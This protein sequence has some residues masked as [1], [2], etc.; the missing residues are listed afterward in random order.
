MLHLS[1]ENRQSI[2]DGLKRKW[3]DAE[4][5]ARMSQR[6]KEMWQSPE[7]RLKL[8]LIHKKLW[9][10]PEY[11]EK[12]L[13]SINQPEVKQRIAQ[14]SAVISKRNWQNPE[15]IIKMSE[16]HK[17]LW[18][19]PEFAKMMSE[20][21]SEAALKRWQD[22]EYR[23]HQIE[24]QI[25]SW[26]DPIIAGKRFAGL[27]KKPTKPEQRLLDIFSKHLPQFQYN[28]DFRL[29]V[30]IGGLI[31]DF[32]NINGRKEVIE[33]FGDYH[34]SPEVIG[35]DWRRGELGKIMIYNSLGWKCFVIWQSELDQLSD[36]EVIEKI[37]SFFARGD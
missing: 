19:D 11:R 21:D 37:E 2:N 1:N 17:Q 32:V 36:T 4:Y 3:Q 29:E 22:P 26:Q 31:P 20:A 34:H 35:N 10:D 25:K 13:V 7:Y 15:F 27:N 6:R 30:M 5:K 16:I 18:Q 28:G 23:Q 14:V 12:I 8:S 24:A 9:Q 33:F